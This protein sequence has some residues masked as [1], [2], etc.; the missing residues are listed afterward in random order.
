MLDANFEMLH[1]KVCASSAKS[2]LVLAAGCAGRTG[3]FF[4]EGL[5]SRGHDF[6]Q[7]L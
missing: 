5:S 2:H 1:L 6:R 7:A 3:D 4:K